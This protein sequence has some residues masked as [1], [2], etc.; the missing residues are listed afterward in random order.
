MLGNT[1][2]VVTVS[3]VGLMLERLEVTGFPIEG[4][5][6]AMLRLGPN[7]NLEPQEFKAEK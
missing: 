1:I 5:N 7:L 2:P 6:L 4:V 3:S